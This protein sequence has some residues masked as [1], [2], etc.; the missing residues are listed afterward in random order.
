MY[1]IDLGRHNCILEPGEG[2]QEI[3]RLYQSDGRGGIK[4]E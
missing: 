1:K 2:F 4:D 3:H